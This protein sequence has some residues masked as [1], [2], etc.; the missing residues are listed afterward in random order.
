MAAT[1]QPG[2]LLRLVSRAGF[3]HRAKYSQIF[4]AFRKFFKA[5]RKF[6]GQ[7]RKG[8]QSISL[9]GFVLGDGPPHADNKQTVP[10]I[11]DLIRRA[12]FFHAAGSMQIYFGE[13][14]VPRWK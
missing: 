3:H 10:G 7:K 12:H 13:I 14:Y 9:E 8:N 6:S 4:K 1:T 5:F 11:L 2:M